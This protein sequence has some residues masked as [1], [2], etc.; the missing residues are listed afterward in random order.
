[1]LRI[2]NPAAP[3][4]GNDGSNIR[5]SRGKARQITTANG[6]TVIIKENSVYSNKGREGA[7]RLAFTCADLDY[8]TRLQ[9]T[10]PSA[11]AVGRSLLCPQQ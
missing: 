10:E 8:N 1:M 2:P 11:T 7:M 5:D 6:R 4:N 3:V 9:D